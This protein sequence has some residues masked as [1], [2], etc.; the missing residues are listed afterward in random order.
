MKKILCQ[1]CTLGFPVT[2]NSHRTVMNMVPAH[3]HINSSMHFNTANLCTCEILLII[4]MMNM[5]V[6]N[7]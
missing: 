6:F 7:D 3:N 4:N 5:I 2:P 1:T